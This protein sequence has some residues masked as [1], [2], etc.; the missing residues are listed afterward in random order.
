MKTLQL[1]LS[2]GYDPRSQGKIALLAAQLDDQL[3]LLKGHVKQMTVE[4]LEWQL[5]P[6][7]NTAGM[8]LAHIAFAE[9]WW[10]AIA[11]KGIAWEPDGKKIVMSVCGIEDDGLPL[12]TDGTHYKELRGYSAEKYLAMLAKARRRSHRELKAWR[13]RDLETCYITPRKSTISY[14]WTLYHVLEHLSGHY[15]QILLL[16]H[17]MRDAGVS[18]R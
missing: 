17:L 16:K 14:G 12:A 7:I 10:L 9:T 2:R 15:G 11:S 18:T 8:L 1:K 5:R 3:K 4:Q 6:G 13:D